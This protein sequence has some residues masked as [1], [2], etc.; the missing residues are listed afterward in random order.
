MLLDLTRRPLL[1]LPHLIPQHIVVRTL[2]SKNVSGLI[3]RQLEANRSSTRYLT[4][5]LK[6]GA[7]LKRGQQTL[8][9]TRLVPDLTEQYAVMLPDPYEVAT[10]SYD[11]VTRHYR[12]DRLRVQ[13]HYKT[14]D[15]WLITVSEMGS[16]PFFAVVAKDLAMGKGFWGTTECDYPLRQRIKDI[17]ESDTEAPESYWSRL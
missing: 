4:E 3:Y 7:V 17:A 8:M 16:E 2:A 10:G 5:N 6:P 11:L 14:V 13:L 15:T 12:E 1:I 9:E